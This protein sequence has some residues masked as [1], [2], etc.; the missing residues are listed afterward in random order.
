VAT[1]DANPKFNSNNPRC[2]G[3]V[4]FKTTFTVT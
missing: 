2:C 4:D 1:E 3:W